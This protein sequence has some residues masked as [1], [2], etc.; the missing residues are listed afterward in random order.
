MGDAMTLLSYQA[1]SDA[2]NEPD[3]QRR[4]MIMPMLDAEE[5]IGPASVDVRLGTRFR[6]LRR[7][8]EGAIDPRAQ[9]Q[10]TIERGQESVTVAF[11]ERLWLHPEQ[12]SWGRRWST[13]ASRPISA[14]TS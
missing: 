9:T 10:H 8:A 6:I 11:G 13:C 12:L 3:L 14:A 2:L 1:L 7:T 4:L 5:Q